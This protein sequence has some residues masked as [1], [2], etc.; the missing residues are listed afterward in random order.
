MNKSCFST[1]LTCLGAIGVIGTAV[2]AVRATPKATKLIDDART[3]KEQPL[4]KLEIVKAAAPA[5]IPSIVIGASTVACIFGANI[6]NKQTQASLASAYALL[7]SSY[8]EYK[9]K[10]VELYGEEADDR[11]KDEIVKDRYEEDNFELPEGEQLFFDFN[12]LQYFTSTMD[13]VIQKVTMDDGLECYI[14]SM[15]DGPYLQY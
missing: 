6:L 8:K 11:V 1:V 9:N 13:K 14:I 3:E 15:P 5:Y 4:T 7:D 12:T 10:V 2:A